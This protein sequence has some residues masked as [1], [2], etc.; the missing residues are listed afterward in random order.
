MFF[1]AAAN[2]THLNC[3]SEEWVTS[4]PDVVS[5]DER[6]Q[7]RAAHITEVAKMKRQSQVYSLLCLAGA[8]SLATLYLL[9]SRPD[10]SKNIR[11]L[12]TN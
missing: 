5:R 9:R 3:C 12:S 8:A 11:T 1:W 4:A 6:A 10:Y 7:M 2:L